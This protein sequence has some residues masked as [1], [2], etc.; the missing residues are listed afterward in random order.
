MGEEESGKSENLK[1]KSSIL[2]IVDFSEEFNIYYDRVWSDHKLDLIDDFIESYET[3]GLTRWKGK[4]A[5][6]TNVPDTYPDAKERKAFAMEYNLYHAHIGIPSWN[7][8]KDV[9][10]STSDQVLHF[11]KVSYKEIKL[12]TVSSHNPMDLPTIDNILK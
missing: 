3:H 1:T 7:N 10:Y 11:Q 5:R 9:P 12:L 8:Y 4:I 6:S 2:Y